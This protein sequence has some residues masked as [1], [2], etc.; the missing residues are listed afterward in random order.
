MINLFLRTL[1]LKRIVFNYLLYNRI[2]QGENHMKIV[3]DVYYVHEV[4]NLIIE[5]VASLGRD[6]SFQ[7][8]EDE[9]KD[10]KAKYTGKEEL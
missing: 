2:I 10:L 8:L 3:D 9:L 1:L 6:L 5:Y 4:K 7:A